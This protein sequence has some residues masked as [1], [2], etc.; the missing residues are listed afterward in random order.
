MNLELF[1][2]RA[3]LLHK[4]LADLYQTATVLPWIPSEL[5]PEAFKELYTT[6]RMVQLAAEELYQQ[7]EE[8]LQ[9]RN[10]L[11]T[12]RQHYQNLF[13][14]APAA[15]LVTNEKGIIKEA[16][17]AASQLLNV[18]QNF[19][20]GKPIINFI[21]R[22]Q[23]QHFYSTLNQIGKSEQVREILLQLKPRHDDYFDAYLTVQSVSQPH[24]KETNLH[25]LLRKISEHQRIESTAIQNHTDLI[26]N[27]PI[28]K[29]SKGENIPLNPLLIWCVRQGLVKLSTFY[30]TG[31]ERL[32]GLA[33]KGMVFG[34]TM[35]SLPIYQATALADVEL[36]SIYTSEIAVVPSLNEILLPKINQRLQQTQSFLFIAGKGKVQDRLHHLL[37]LLK[38]QI[39]EPFPGGTRLTFRLT[40][41]DMASACATTRVTIT[42][43]LGQ[44][45]EQGLISFDDKKHIICKHS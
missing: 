9:N 42:R 34:S 3:E 22:E 4:H 26:E 20:V 37:E 39:G 38:Q 44:F 14:F 32:T 10:L 30:E 8:L 13:E 40:H 1:V 36:V 43:L 11:E 41:E 7:N 25:W 28:H 18:A 2:Q 6:S 35:T 45:Q 17:R 31:A 15:Y 12:Q 16:N 24:G 27:S 5:L 23:H 21:P 19:L 29:Y 33:T